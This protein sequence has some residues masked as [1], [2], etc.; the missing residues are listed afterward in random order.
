MNSF[1]KGES[2]IRNAL[3]SAVA[4]EIEERFDV[5][6]EPE[7][8]LIVTHH[9]GPCSQDSSQV[10]HPVVFDHNRQFFY[11]SLKNSIAIFFALLYV[12]PMRRSGTG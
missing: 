9:N 12:T 6:L 4:D 7:W 8:A 3:L 5:S 11:G 10:K 2:S 1:A